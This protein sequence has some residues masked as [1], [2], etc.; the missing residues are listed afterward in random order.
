LAVIE[1]LW[2]QGDVSAVVLSGAEGAG[3][4]RLL[5]ESLQR[6]AASGREV[7]RFVGS[8]AAASVPFGAFARLLSGAAPRPGD[9]LG[10][11]LSAVEALSRAAGRLPLVV[12]VDDA[13]HLDQAA[14][15]LLHQL[16]YSGRAFVL[17]T[18]RIGETAREPIRALWDNGPGR[19]IEVPVM[20][21]P[22][23]A[24]LLASVLGGPVAAA[25]VSDLHRTTRGNLVL[26]HKIV[27][28]SL[29]SGALFRDDGGWHWEGLDGLPS[30]GDLGDPRLEDLTDPERTVLELVAL[31]DGLELPTLEILVPGSALGALERHGFL[32]L[33]ADGRRYRVTL[34]RPADAHA[35]R[36][37][38][39]PLR[40]LLLGQ[41]LAAARATLPR[42]RATDRHDPPQRRSAALPS[43]L[44]VDRLT[45]R[46]RTIVTLTA[47]GLS[48]REIAEHLC[49]ALRTVENHL[50]RAFPKLGVSSRQELQS[51]ADADLSGTPLRTA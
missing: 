22:A 13:H 3:A 45:P 7:E 29:E 36:H 26:L 43:L 37:S 42:R 20:D 47:A 24:R 44:T 2:A 19:R 10:V 33:T 48:N 49:V 27:V 9:R 40:A 8:Q 23:T 11:F 5:D 35:L 21:Q 46:E 34:A 14:A 28:A 41:R 50:Y 1:A 4:T 25:T 18:V 17:A 16:A 31:A 12:G 15:A 38:L 30:L 39:P 6:L 51:M 32:T